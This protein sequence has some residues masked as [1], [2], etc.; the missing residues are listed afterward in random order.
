VRRFDGA[1]GLQW[2]SKPVG[3]DGVVVHE[4]G[5]PLV[6]GE[7]EWDPPGGCAP[8]VSMQRPAL[9]RARRPRIDLRPPA[10]RCGVGVAAATLPSSARRA[11]SPTRAAA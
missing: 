9:S 5:P 7:G 8:S 4:A 10:S 6:R 3:L 2:S 1:G 11:C